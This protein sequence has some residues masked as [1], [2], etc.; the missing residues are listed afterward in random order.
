MMNGNHYDDKVDAWSLG[1][2]FLE[3]WIGQRID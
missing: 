3:I 1:I 2:V